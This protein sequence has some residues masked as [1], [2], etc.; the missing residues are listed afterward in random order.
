MF[1]IKLCLVIH[2]AIYMYYTALIYIPQEA[3]FNYRN[4]LYS[5]CGLL[6]E[7]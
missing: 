4:M 5:S 3:E 1:K 7:K 6:V 2:E